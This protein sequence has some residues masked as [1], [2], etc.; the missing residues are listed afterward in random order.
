MTKWWTYYIL[1]VYSQQFFSN[2]IFYYILDLTNRESYEMFFKVLQKNAFDH[3]NNQNLC[4]GSKTKKMFPSH[5]NVANWG[6]PF[7]GYRG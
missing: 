7:T 6:V 5:N 2:I 4:K 1:T 3:K